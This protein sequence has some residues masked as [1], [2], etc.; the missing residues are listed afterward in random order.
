MRGAPTPSRRIH[1]RMGIIPADAGSTSDGLVEPA[2]LSLGDPGSS[3]RMRGALKLGLPIHVLSRIIPADAGST[4]TPTRS[5]CRS[6]NHPRGC[7]EHLLMY[8]DYLCHLGSSPR[9]RGTQALA[10][11]R[12][13]WA[14]IIPADA[15]STILA[16][17]RAA[18]EL[19][20]PRGCGEHA[21]LTYQVPSVIGSSP[22]M[23][24]ARRVAALVDRDRRIIPADAGNTP[25]LRRYS[26]LLGIIPADAGSTHFRESPCVD[27]W[28]HPRGCGEHNMLNFPALR[29]E[30]SSPRMRGA[31][32]WTCH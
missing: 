11:D 27:K 1:Q 12:P 10:P 16:Y 15:G 20:H 3:P 13:A 17:T 7:G 8:I 14:G 26:T 4:G 9:M 24:G 6:T 23:R 19:D 22:R 29:N 21:G 2:A 30:G 31:R 25:R 18:S 32:P 28:D 5:C